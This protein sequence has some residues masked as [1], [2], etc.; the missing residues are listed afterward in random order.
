MLV[1]LTAPQV[2]YLKFL[3]AHRITDELKYFLNK[4]QAYLRFGRANVE[5]WV[6]N[7]EVNIFQRP[8]CTEY[9]FSELLSAA[10]N[11][12]DY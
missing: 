2:Q 8:K 4:R 3:V 11:K 9:R 5:R 1:D 10:E 7:G 12:Q 6:K